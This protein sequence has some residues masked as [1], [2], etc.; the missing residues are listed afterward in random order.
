MKKII[1]SDY[2]TVLI[3]DYIYPYEVLEEIKLDEFLTEV[4][5]LCYAEGKIIGKYK[6]NIVELYFTSEEKEN[7][8][9]QNYSSFSLEYQKLINA[10][11]KSE[12]ILDAK[13]GKIP[14]KK[15]QIIYLNYLNE[16]LDKL[17]SNK[18]KNF[19]GNIKYSFKEMIS[20]LYFEKHYIFN[21]FC[22]VSGG[23][24]LFVCLADKLSIAPSLI[25]LSLPVIPNVIYPFFKDLILKQINDVIYTKKEKKKLIE[26]ISNVKQKNFSKEENENFEERFTVDYKTTV[27][28]LNN[29]SKLTLSLENIKDLSQRKELA[30]ELQQLLFLFNESKKKLD[31]LNPK[32]HHMILKDRVNL[33]QTISLKLTEIEQKMNYLISKQEQKETEEEVVN[34]LQKKLQLYAGTSN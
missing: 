2:G 28:I 11:N 5:D 8:L 18:L 27:D 3:K 34:D 20:D 15:S 33:E 19:W 10:V 29:I 13:G 25:T 32:K 16:E 4:K 9:N 6:N 17:K 23:L 22:L 14:D 1:I 24:T 26:T 30:I 12:I 21:I 31:S 7:Y